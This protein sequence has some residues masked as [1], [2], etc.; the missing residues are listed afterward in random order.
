MNDER[1]IIT[2]G[3]AVPHPHSIRVYINNEWVQD[4]ITPDTS[5]K[6]RAEELHELLKVCSQPL[7]TFDAWETLRLSPNYKVDYVLYGNYGP[8]QIEKKI[9]RIFNVEDDGNFMF[10]R[11]HCS[12]LIHQEDFSIEEALSLDAF[13]STA[14]KQVCLE[15]VHNS[16]G[17]TAIFL[18]L[19]RN[20]SAKHYTLN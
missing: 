2:K 3:K 4:L 6:E 1:F 7:E 14:Y 16:T 20:Y 12:D 10:I 19:P 5:N 9:E 18:L 8:I 15:N 13:F 17:E 11:I